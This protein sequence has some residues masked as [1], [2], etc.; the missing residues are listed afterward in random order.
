[1]TRRDF[2]A[3]LATAPLLAA[4]PS[5]QPRVRLGIDLFSLRS[6][7]WTPFQYL[8]YCARQ[9][10]QVVH[11]SEIRFI[12]SLDPAHLQKVRKYADHLGLDLEIGMKS[13][14]PT[15]RMFDKSQGAAEQQLG[16]MIDAAR[17]VRS[18][19]VRC[20]L[21]SAEDR[22]PGPLSRHIDDMVQVLKNVESKAAAANVKIAIENHAG[23]MQSWELKGLIEAAG[24]A[25]VGVCLDSGNP[26]WTLES[27]HVALE[28]LHPYVLTSHVRDS[29]VWR[30]SDGNV[31]VTWVEM[32]R[33]NVDIA[34]YVKKFVQ[35]C[36]GK[37]LSMETIL[38]GPRNFP[39]SDSNFWDAYRE[40]PA[41]EYEKYLELAQNGQPYPKQDWEAKDEA[42]RQ[43]A[44]LEESLAY[45]R[46][47]LDLPV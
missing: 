38:Y 46:K 43:R 26:L 19:I 25:F 5:H 8:D 23:D 3:L 22:V 20:V 31:A 18:P 33:G 7:N 28:T 4:A 14:C 13:I 12:G 34:S 35:L 21:G 1:M 27:P 36:P 15:S 11:F 40:V 45:T 24:P 29:A 9:H 44:A 10:V 42:A 37:A 16:R 39:V 32:G 30:T 47:V 2:A 17:I 6:Q 41:W